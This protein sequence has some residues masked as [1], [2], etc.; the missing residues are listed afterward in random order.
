MLAVSDSNTALFGG[1][2]ADLI[3]TGGRIDKA[4][5]AV[6]TL[7]DYD[8]KDEKTDIVS[9]SAGNVFA[10]D[11]GD[12]VIVDVMS[13]AKL[14]FDEATDS[15]GILQSLRTGYENV[16]NAIETITK[17]VSDVIDAATSFLPDL[18]SIPSIGTVE[19]KA[20]LTMG[21]AGN[22]VLS[23]AGQL[24]GEGGDDTYLIWAGDT[25]VI[26]ERITGSITDALSSIGAD[27][28]EL[29]LI[30]QA[31]G[32]RDTVELRSLAGDPLSAD[33]L[34]FKKV[35][36][37]LHIQSGGDTLATI[38]GMNN[39]TTRVEWLRLVDNG[40]AFVFDLE[41]VWD[42]IETAGFDALDA[43][44]V[45]QGPTAAEMIFDQVASNMGT[46]SLFDAELAGL[47]TD[48]LSNAA[49]LAA[50]AVETLIP[51][52]DLI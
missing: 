37:A 1:A 46:L 6:G 34:E 25:A 35:D 43:L 5:D 49:D 18:P 23:G 10:G 12:D 50:T 38:L 39:A 11:D 9:L 22:D 33:E 52:T 7:Q 3:L 13:L 29:D 48:H 14:A 20:N 24:S 40:D 28:P 8:S 2:G 4:F 15:S 32:G 51:E 21:G 45:D 19:L 30:A 26:S 41:A 44:V 27:I 47:V 31:P 36:G 42:Q 17:P 16:V